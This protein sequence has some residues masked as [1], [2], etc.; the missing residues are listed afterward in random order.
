MLDSE[1]EY[2]TGKPNED[3]SIEELEP[4][5]ETTNGPY[6]LNIS[7]PTK[8]LYLGQ[9]QIDLIGITQLASPD[10]LESFIK[11]CAE[12][13]YTTR[14]IERLKETFPESKRTIFTDYCSKIPSTKTPTE[15]SYLVRRNIEVPEL[16]EAEVD[17]I[18]NLY[19][20][21]YQNLAIERL[22]KQNKKA[23]QAIR[24]NFFRRQTADYDDVKYTTYEE[25]ENL[26][27]KLSDFNCL[28]ITSGKY[29][30]VKNDEEF[31][32]YH[33]NRALEFAKKN[34]LQVRY[35]SLLTQDMPLDFRKKESLKIFVQ[36][37]IDFINSHNAEIKSKNNGEEKGL[38]TSVDL[39]NEIISIHPNSEGEYENI[40]EQSG[41][42][43]EDIID[44]F[45]YAKNHKPEGVSYV[46]N[47]AF[48]EVPEK[49]A[50]QLEIAR[51]LSAAGLIDTFG[52]QM[53]IST[54]TKAKNITESFADLKQL[55]DETGLKIAITEFDCYVPPKT[56]T[57][58]QK[59]GC[60]DKEIRQIAIELKKEKIQ[61]VERIAEESQIAFSEVG[62]WS[63][64]DSM[65]HNKRRARLNDPKTT[66]ESLY[67]GLYGDELKNK[68]AT[69]T[70]SVARKIPSYS[71][72][73]QH[74]LEERHPIKPETSTSLSQQ[75]DSAKV[76]TKKSNTTVN[77]APS[78]GESNGYANVPILLI[79]ILL[80][81]AIVHI[82]VTM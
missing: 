32:S 67:G 5:D 10:E 46:Y 1:L 12:F 38:I 54:N 36:E 58:L 41:L 57:K 79:M 37:S 26:G 18:M 80:L 31:D 52:T 6:F 19:Y 9:T 51:K 3:P 50:K 44:I 43:T 20:R 30:C 55:S 78:G 17:E 4:L 45:S 40:W 13:S 28:L 49:R 72:E 74:M 8:T 29:S 7:S 14:E 11:D 22:G 68:A 34:G 25:M 64:T 69:K 75:K 62:Y 42:T 65:D 24:D 39:M 71:E 81:V 59:N 73:L 27:K 76:F 61:E 56:L 35:H 60:T 16:D 48:V 66:P 2:L 63:A 15:R 82:I 23:L 47:E 77:N 53:H 33:V 70:K 21:G